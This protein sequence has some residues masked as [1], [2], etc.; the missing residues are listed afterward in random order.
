[1]EYWLVSYQFSLGVRENYMEIG[2]TYFSSQGTIHNCIDKYHYSGENSIK[3]L[4]E[5][6]NCR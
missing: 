5:M 6:S 4:T 2:F 3:V 1:M